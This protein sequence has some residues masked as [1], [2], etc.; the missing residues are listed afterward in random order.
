[1]KSKSL[2]Y[3]P[4]DE[5]ELLFEEVY[6]EHL[7]FVYQPPREIP[8]VCPKCGRVLYKKDCVWVEEL[9]PS[10]GLPNPIGA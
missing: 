9:Y 5:D 6:D 4:N 10:D 8:Q 7:D 2:F 3:C 1:M